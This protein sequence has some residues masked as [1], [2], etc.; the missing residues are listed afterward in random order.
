MRILITATPGLSATGSVPPLA[1]GGL[2]LRNRFAREDAGFDV[3]FAD[4]DEDLAEQVID[5]LTRRS[6]GPRDAVMLYI[7]ARTLLSR[8]GELYL[9]LDPE[10]A[11]V[12]DALA[13]VA[14]SL[15]DAAPGW[16]LIVLDLVDAR[17]D[18]DPTRIQTLVRAAEAAID[19]AASDIELV[20][21]LR[22]EEVSGAE[23]SP[24]V[25]AL[26]GE[27]DAVDRNQGLTMRSVFDRVHRRLHGDVAYLHHSR[28]RVTFEL[29][30]LAKGRR[31]PS[32]IPPP[33]ASDARSSVHPAVA[34]LSSSEDMPGPHPES[35]KRRAFIPLPAPSVPSISMAHLPGDDGPDSDDEWATVDPVLLL[36]RPLDAPPGAS[37]P[38]PSASMYPPSSSSFPPPT[39]TPVAFSSGNSVPPSGPVSGVPMSGVPSSVAPSSMAPSSRLTRE[40]SPLARYTVEGELLASQGDMSGAIALFRKALALLGPSGEP[41]LRAEMYT[42]IGELRAQSGTPED[43]I[44]DYEKALALRPG[45][46]PALEALIVLCSKEKDWRGVMSAEERLLATIDSTTVRFERMIEFAARW[47]DEAEKPGRARHLFERAR[48]LQPT[49]PVLDE[50]IRRV[51]LKMLKKPQV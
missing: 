32:A 8:E 2:D 12:G 20:V 6:C 13:D 5:V 35:S 14:A 4:P 40:I 31:D 30:P 1:V 21:S 47:E 39:R 18:V 51:S 26:I 44:S 42:R 33:F 27:M 3:V 48:E 38:P 15:R 9:C 50:Q 24:F 16:K 36:G 45:H 41:N 43:A 11:N 49:N 17:L 22:S 29:L 25:D 23:S 34:L 10:E 19:F 28:A 37:L 7:A 46:V